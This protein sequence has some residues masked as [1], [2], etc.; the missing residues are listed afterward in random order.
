VVAIYG[1]SGMTEVNNKFYKIK[2]LTQNT[3]K[4]VGTDSTGW[5][6]FSGTALVA[7]CMPSM[8]VSWAVSNITQASPAVVT[9]TQAPAEVDGTKVEFH[10]L[11][12]MTSLEAATAYIKQV[13][14]QPTKYELYTD[15]GLTTPLNSSGYA[16]YTGNGFMTAY[17]DPNTMETGIHYENGPDNKTSNNIFRGVR[18][19]VGGMAV[20]S[21]GWGGTHTDNHFHNFNLDGSMYAHYISGGKNRIIAPYIDGPTKYGFI[22]EGGL[23]DVVGIQH[24]HN[25]GSIWLARDNYPITHRTTSGSAAV[26]TWGGVLEGGASSR[27]FA[28][29][30]GSGSFYPNRTVLQYVSHFPDDELTP[31]ADPR[32][33]GA[34]QPLIDPSIG[35]AID[36]SSMSKQI[37][38]SGTFDLQ[39][40]SGVV[41]ITETQATGYGALLVAGN[42]G[43]AI[44]GNNATANALF[45][46]TLSPAS[47][48]IGLAVTGNKI[49]VTNNYGSAITVCVGGFRTRNII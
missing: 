41:S 7:A 37:A 27:I 32:F 19:G 15:A 42:A 10:A 16:T 1:A 18:I 13:A 43:I 9:L 45:K 49:R 29:H 28:D 38:Q 34:I 36:S 35:W 39:T 46:N 22:W 24:Y 4:L 21:A 31:R 8:R 5:G 23:N 47:G 30:I 3:F 33:Y 48:E 25:P 2:R 14:G 20:N 26:R 11:E 40:G 17:V 12:G 6:T 44:V